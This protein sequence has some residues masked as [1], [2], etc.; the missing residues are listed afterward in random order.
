VIVDEYF[1]GMYEKID[2]VIF[3]QIIE[4]EIIYQIQPTLVLLAYITVVPK[5]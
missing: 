2:I 3:L 4:I 1:L 5:F